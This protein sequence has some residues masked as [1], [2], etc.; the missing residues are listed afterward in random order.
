MSRTTAPRRRVALFLVGAVLSACTSTVVPPSAPKV[1]IVSSLPLQG[2]DRTTTV[3]IVNAIKMALAEAGGMAGRTTVVYESYD[4][5]S[6]ATGLWHGPVEERNARRAAADPD[7]VAYIGPFNSPAARLSIPINC[8]AGL[9]MV[10]PANTYTGLTKRWAADEPS[11]YYPNC[12]RN[13]A[14]VI[15]SDDLQGAV[16]AR[17]AKDLGVR[18]VYVVEDGLLFGS[19]VASA[20]RT[21]AGRI[22]LQ[23]VGHEQ[24]RP[25]ALPMVAS[26]V[27]ASRPD[28][29]Y[30]GGVV[31][32][33]TGALWKGVKS[34]SPSTRFMGAFGLFDPLLLQLA[35]DDAL[36]TY[37]TWEGVNVDDYTGRQREWA[38]TYMARYGQ[39]PGV[40]AIYGYEAARVILAAIERA[41]ARARDRNLIREL[42]METK[43]FDGVLGRWSFD[44][45]GDTT[46]GM[47]PGL[48]VVKGRD[49][50][51]SFRFV[52]VLN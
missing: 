7:V 9:V 23:E 50:E 25:G 28:L 12:A 16:A 48:V 37:L 40:H 15:A 36:G 14:R 33:D 8:A 34:A 39:R 45:D 46:L 41:G 6:A 5:S 47:F 31:R 22:G 51:S 26:R 18:T 10:S 43:D 49:F 35:G 44:P 19:V 38:E 21:E 11:K 3:T 52:K 32:N 17:W 42:V 24:A 1:T 30:Y 27:A 29:V 13:F 2:P 20:F 4:D